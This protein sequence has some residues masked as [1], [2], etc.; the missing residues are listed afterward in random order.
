MKTKIMFAT[1]VLAL[2]V[3]LVPKVKAA[4]MGTAFTYQGHLMDANSP[5]DGLYDFEFKLWMD[6]SEIVYPPQVGD[7]LTMNDLDV[8]DGYFT[9]ELDFNNPFA[10]NGDARWLEIGVRPGD[11]NDPNAFVTLSPRTELTPTPYALNVRVPL[12][13]S[14]NEAGAAI[15]VTNSAVYGGIGVYSEVMG[16]NGHA[17]YGK[18]TGDDSSGIFGEATNEDGTGVLGYASADASYGVMGSH[19]DSRTV[20]R[21]GSSWY[22]AYGGDLDSGKYGYLG[23]SDY[24]GYFNGRVFVQMPSGTPTLWQR[25]PGFVIRGGAYNSGIPLYVQDSSGDSRFIVSSTGAVGIGTANPVELLHLASLVGIDLKIEADTDN[26]GED[27][28]ARLV[29]SQDGGQVTG[30]IGY[31][32][33][34]NKL[35]IMQ[36]YND[37]L[38]L[39]TNNTDRLTIT[40]DGKVGIGTSSPFATLDVIS[41]SLSSLFVQNTGTVANAWFAVSNASG[42]NAILASSNSSVSPAVFIT[43]TAGGGALK[44][45]GTAEVTVLQIMGADLAEKFPVSEEVKPGMVVAI[46]PEHPGKLCLSR[47]AYNRCVAGV[48]SGANGLPAGAV[49]GN[50]PGQEDAMPIALSGRVWVYCDAADHPVEAGDLLTTA[51]RIGHA[52]AVTDYERAHGTVIGKAMTGLKNEK[53]GLVLALVNLQ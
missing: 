3:W 49:L 28:N 52:M 38:I 35:E 31:R 17:V 39:G 16:R 40:G 53:S 46:D 7:T 10:F 20:G 50:L 43:N 15:T 25:E 34:L 12:V 4:P 36:E 45:N 29:L 11:S 9:V 51:E 8:I 13:L 5:T 2:M 33:G 32:A 22:G 30:R 14:H 26:S 6:P 48:V 19:I 18:A 47:G 23:S 37:S 1:M 27:E 41:S 24:A 42:G 44:V 21:L